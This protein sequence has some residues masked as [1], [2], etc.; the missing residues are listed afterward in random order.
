MKKLQDEIIDIYEP[1]IVSLVHSMFE[2]LN[3]LHRMLRN[4]SH[5]LEEPLSHSS[6]KQD[7]KVMS[8]YLVGL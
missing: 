4:L 7:V 6:S 8:D 5:I 3:G 2:E 1:L